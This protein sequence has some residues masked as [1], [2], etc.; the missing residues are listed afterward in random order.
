[1]AFRYLETA[2]TNLIYALGKHIQA[3]SSRSREN[4]T[5]SNRS[6]TKV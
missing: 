1:M 4:I 5:V 2:E 3:S 6:L